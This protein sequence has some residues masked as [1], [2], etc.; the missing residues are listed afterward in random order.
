MTFIIHGATGAQGAPL[1]SRLLKAGKHAVAAVRNASAVKDMPAVAVDNASVDSLAAAYRDAEGVFFHLPLA[2]EADRVQHA[3]NFAQAVTRA[4]PRRVVISTSGY[5]VDE[6]GSPTQ[7]PP[8]NAVAVLIREIERTGVSC[9]VVAPRLYLENLLLPIQFEPVKAE[10][11]LRYPLRPDYPVSWSS[12]LD[13]AEVVERLLM[14]ASITGIVGVG[15]SPGLTGADLAKGFSQHLGQEVTFE[16]ITP[17]RFG[18]MLTPLFGAGAA[19]G[20]V[21]GYQAMARKS[22]SVIAQETSAQRLLG[23]APRSVQQWLA[24]VLA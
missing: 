21:A 2:S 19:A 11:V 4:K 1:I 18:E 13:V 16:G 17:E 22:G 12:H 23:L 3:H 9:A 7:V 6:P 10:G 20:V 15:H 8:E 24:E 14:D 5:V